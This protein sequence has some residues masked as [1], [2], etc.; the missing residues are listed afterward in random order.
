MKVKTLKI[1]GV[2]GIE[3]LEL[4]FDPTLNVICGPNGVGKTTIL[5]CI[6][7]MFSHGETSILKRNVKHDSSTISMSVENQGTEISSE[8]SFTAF[9]PNKNVQVS[10]LHQFSQY[11]LSLKTTRTFHYI[12][13]QSIGRDP[14]KQAHILWRDATGGIALNDIKNW[15]VNRY[16]YLPHSGALNDAQISNFE[17]ARKCFSVLNEDFTFSHVAAS[18]NE[19]VISTPSGKIYYEYL[20]SGF[21]STLSI[22]FGIIKEIE[23]R[24]SDPAIRAED[25]EGIVVIDELELHLHPEWQAKIAEILIKIFPKIQFIATTHSPHIIQAIEPS[26]IIA[27]ETIEGKT[28]LREL[29]ISKYGFKGWTV[30][31]VLA[32]VMGMLDTRTDIFLSTVDS[33][34][35]AIEA[36]DYAKANEVYSELDKL[37]HPDNHLRKLLKFQLVSIQEAKID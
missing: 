14:E 33:F 23:F 8:I 28:V 35:S 20:S 10:G 2:G 13:L 31:E 11:L 34:S 26:Q 4:K 25:F 27:L 21:K 7:H 32:D 19:I 30:E 9:E 17:L 22:L 37:L 16:L 24:F 3:E 6:A 12:P 5:E 1:L 36:E 29:P 18:T 15:F